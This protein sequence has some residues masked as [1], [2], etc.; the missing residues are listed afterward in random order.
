MTTKFASNFNETIPV[1]DTCG[2]FHLA[3]NVNQT[4]TVPGTNDKIYKAIIGGNLT[5]HL[6][7]GV[8]AT[9][10]PPALGLNSSDG[11]VLIN[12]FFNTFY[13]KGGDEINLTTPDAS[14]AYVGVSLLLLPS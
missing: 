4:Y 10:V 9:P 6:F 7:V 11:N 12:P 3:Q 1:S 2:Q 13:V 8:N 5:A 14:G